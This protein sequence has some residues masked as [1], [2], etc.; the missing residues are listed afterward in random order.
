MSKCY[1]Y[2]DGYCTFDKTIQEQEESEMFWECDG[3]WESQSACGMEEQE[4]D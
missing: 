2:E 4:N 3:T 1:F